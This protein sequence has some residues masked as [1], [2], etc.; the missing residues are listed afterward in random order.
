[1]SYWYWTYNMQLLPCGPYYTK[2]DRQCTWNVTL[3]HVRITIVTMETRQ[4]FPFILFKS[5]SLS[6]TTNT[7]S[8]A[9]ET[10]QCDLFVFALHM[11]LPI[12]WNTLTAS[13]KV[14]DIVVRCK[15]NSDFLD[16][17]SRKSPIS[18]FMKSV[19]WE[20]RRYMR[21]DGHE[22][23]KDASRNYANVHK[24][25]VNHTNVPMI[26]ALIITCVSAFLPYLSCMKIASFLR[27]TIFASVACVALA[28]FS[29]LSHKRHD[30]RKKLLN[31]KYVFRFS[32]QLLSETCLIPQRIQ[33][34]IIINLRRSLCRGTTILVRF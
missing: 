10:Q 27:C 25:P 21:T 16:R 14:P 1:M 18:N 12:T 17:F 30:Y 31:I 4:C 11:S 8:F 32:L 9:L 28:Y 15:P 24:K 26:Q 23:A 22:E 33:R 6:T 13:C 29:T 20:P 7:E 3:W 5:M 34:N 19:Q 2:Q